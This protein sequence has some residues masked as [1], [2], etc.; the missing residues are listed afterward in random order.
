MWSLWT[1]ALELGFGR[2]A[3]LEGSDAGRGAKTSMGPSA[4]AGAV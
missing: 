3:L 1:L 4:E 2:R